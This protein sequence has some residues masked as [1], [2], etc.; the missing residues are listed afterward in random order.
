MRRALA[1]VVL[2]LTTVGCGS[3]HHG[4]R[5]HEGATATSF[6]HAHEAFVAAIN[7]N[8]YDAV[9]GLM[10]E[11]VVFMTPNASPLVGKEAVGAWVAGYVEAFTTHWDKRTVTLVVR[12]DRAIERYSYTSTDVPKGGGD[13]IVDTGWGLAIY[14]FDADGV[15]RLSQDA[16]A[17]DQP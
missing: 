13:P 7:A 2:S 9:M 3:L 16:F 6:H 10:T 12:G 5:A 14:R 1:L 8:D 17:S 15:W 4:D 11:D